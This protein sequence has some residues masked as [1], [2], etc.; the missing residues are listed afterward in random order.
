VSVLP[1]NDMKPL[2]RQLF[3]HLPAVAAAAAAYLRRQPGSNR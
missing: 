2:R 1:G 3:L